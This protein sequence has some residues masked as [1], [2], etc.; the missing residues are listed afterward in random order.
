M[1]YTPN[2]AVIWRGPSLTDGS[3]IVVAV[4]G[5]NRESPCV[6]IFGVLDPVRPLNPIRINAYRGRYEHRAPF[7]LPGYVIARGKREAVP[8]EVWAALDA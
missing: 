3:P 1:T 4:T 5:T 6:W 8:G 7:P 2:A